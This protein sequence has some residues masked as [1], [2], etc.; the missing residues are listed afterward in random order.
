MKPERFLVYRK[1]L[2]EKKIRAK[3]DLWG[4][5]IVTFSAAG[6][7]FVFLFWCGVDYLTVK[8]PNYPQNIRDGRYEWVLILIPVVLAGASYLFFRRR[9][10]DFSEKMLISV[11]AVVLSLVG[12]AILILFLGIPFHFR[13]GGSW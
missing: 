5:P 12:G 7:V 1:A 9:L 11:C 2:E 4:L 13:I 3:R 10:S 6:G 8:S